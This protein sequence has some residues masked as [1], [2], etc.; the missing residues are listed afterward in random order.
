[1]SLLSTGGRGERELPI[2]FPLRIREEVRKRKVGKEDQF[3]LPH[4]KKKTKRGES[5]EKRGKKEVLPAPS[6][7]RRLHRRAKK[8]GRM[9]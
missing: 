5:W 7:T 8:G 4:S 9:R 6:L 1:M 3:D 2:F